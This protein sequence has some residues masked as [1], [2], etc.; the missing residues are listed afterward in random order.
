[1]QKINDKWIRLGGVALLSINLFL[2]GS[3]QRP[4]MAELLYVIIYLASVIIILETGRF[5]ILYLHK[6][7]SESGRGRSRFWKTCLFV[8]VSNFILILSTF[9]ISHFIRHIRPNITSFLLIAILISGI[10]LALVQAGVYEGL[11]YFMRVRKLEQEKEELLRIN[12]QSQF[13]SLKQQVN[14]HF[15]FNSINTVSSLIDK[16]PEKAKKFLVEMSKV[17]RYLLQA[18]EEQLVTLET[19]LKFVEPYF[20]LLKTRFNEGLDLNIQIDNGCK[21]FLLPALTLQLLIENA[22]KHNVVE[23]EKPL[24]I[25]IATNNGF[26]S[27]VNNLQKKRNQ[28]ASTKIGLANIMAKYKL[29]NEREI[30]VKETDD[31][32][33]VLIPL[34][35]NN[36]L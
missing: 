31:K 34:I 21:N 7:T 35:Q 23:K 22:I 6:R 8:S 1:M 30:I 24:T 9:C 15:L 25:S 12:L 27:V 5:I 4:L 17:Y 3:G 18:N 36:G 19:E 32:F 33:T 20:H 10:V 14:P 28:I 11:F 2:L 13:D 16:D 29:L 26:L